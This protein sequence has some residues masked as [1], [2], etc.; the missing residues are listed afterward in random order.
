MVQQETQTGKREP[1]KT[2]ATR[3]EFFKST[4]ALVAG[5]VA[6]GS[7][8]PNSSSGSWQDEEQ[9]KKVE[10]NKGKIFKS[11]KWGMIGE[12]GSVLEKFQLQRELGY[13]GMELV[14]PTDLKVDE[15]LA[16]SRETGMPIHGLVNQRHWSDG[17]RLSEPNP[18]ARE[19]GRKVLE[20]CLRDA[21]AFG[22]DTVLL[23]PG[24]VNGKDETHDHVWKRSIVEIRKVLPLASRLGIRI[25]IENVWNGFCEKPEQLRDYIDEINSPWVGVYFD[26]G[27]VRKCGPSEDWVRTLG[28]RFVMLDVKDWSKGNSFKSKIGDGDVNW[29]E[30]CKALEEIQFRGWCTAEVT[31]GKK[32]RLQDIAS[33]MDRVLKLK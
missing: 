31:G 17:F 32:D 23:V 33:R 14:S 25:L 10:S 27:N 26:I 22:G 7:L 16:A 9:E 1:D 13:D 11:V 21:K 8:L 24:R 18:E 3:R 28:N 29:P 12:G 2:G 4:S 30:V 6:A 20:Q 5:T 19:K 15:L